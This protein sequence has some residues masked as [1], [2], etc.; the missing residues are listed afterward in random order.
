MPAPVALP[1][2]SAVH[3]DGNVNVVIVDPHLAERT[4][5]YPYKNQQRDADN[6][7]TNNPT[8]LQ[9]IGLRFLALRRVR[10]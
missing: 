1:S 8:F 3:N 6:D 7:Q 2:G 4:A 10:G 5:R 9:P